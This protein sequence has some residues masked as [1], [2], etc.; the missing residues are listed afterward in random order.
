MSFALKAQR[1]EC[2]G[3]SIRGTGHIIKVRQGTVKGWSLERATGQKGKE[4]PRVERA[5]R[6]IYKLY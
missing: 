6:G 1:P 5:S 4:G 3:V 2:Q